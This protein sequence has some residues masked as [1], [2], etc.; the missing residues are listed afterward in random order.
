MPLFGKSSKNPG[1][2]VKQLKESLMVL[3]KQHNGESQKKFEK[4]H[5]DVS[6]YIFTI[7]SLLFSSESDQQS[8][9]ILAQMSQEMYNSAVISLLIKNLQNVE[10]EAR[11]ES[12]EIF[13]HVLRRQIGTRTPTVEYICTTDEILVSLCRGFENLTINHNTSAM[14]RECLR[15]ESLAK[16][17][18]FSEVFQD[19]FKY[20]ECSHFDVAADAFT[21]FKDLLTRH[22]TIAANYLE[23]H[24]ESFFF[25]Y[26]QLLISQNFVTQLNSLKL[27]AELL[28]DRNNS[29][30][31]KK[32]INDSENL[33][34]TMTLLL[35]QAPV[36]KYEAFSIFKIF[37]L[38]PKKP[39]DINVILLKN[40]ELLRKLFV[41]F[42][43]E[44][45][46]LNLFQA[47]K[48]SIVKEINDL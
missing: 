37:I 33:K 43:P 27:L 9:I 19:F 11:K 13:S 12:V 18:L 35:H 29:S 20:V 36:I 39:E 32:Y 28:T 6:K 2:A 45:D 5:D 7:S 21:T 41:N 17:V 23:T 15:Y 3:E 25:S 48:S 47:E 8:D 1:E 46:D 26:N 31:M 14:L 10:F 4:A 44:L 30:V 40:K 22:K 16:I 24:Y 34:T 38:N 42:L